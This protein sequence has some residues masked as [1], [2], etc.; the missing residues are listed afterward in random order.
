MLTMF[1]SISEI[2]SRKWYYIPLQVGMYQGVP[3]YET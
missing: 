2:G 1:G 3:K